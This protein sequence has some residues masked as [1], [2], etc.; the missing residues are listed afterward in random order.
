[1]AEGIMKHLAGDQFDVYS[2]GVSPIEIQPKTFIVMSEKG[3]DISDQRP[4][5]IDDYKDI[6]FDYVITL[7]GH[8]KETCPVF[9]GAQN[10]HWPITDP[11]NA[12]G[13][14]DAKLTAYRQSRD[15]IWSQIQAFMN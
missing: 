9:K 14:D 4:N 13:S 11:Y 1:M 5:H 7:C 10:L 6:D 2:A 3:I 12:T 8:A 15:D